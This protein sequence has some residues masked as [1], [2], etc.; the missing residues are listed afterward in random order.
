MMSSITE[1]IAARQRAEQVVDMIG[2]ESPRFWEEL[3]R[4]AGEKLPAKPAGY[5]PLAPMDEQ[6]AIRFEASEMPYGVHIGQQIGMIEARYIGW[7]AENEFTTKLR[8]Y[9]KSARFQQRQAE[10]GE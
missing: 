10:E 5:D 6:E 2:D 9:V 1:N 4:L 7:L 8:R 3:A